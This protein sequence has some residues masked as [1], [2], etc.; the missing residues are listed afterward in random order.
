[1][2]KFSTPAL[3]ITLNPSDVNNPLVAI[4]AGMDPDVWRSLDSHAQ[5]EFIA[6]HPAPAAQ[7]F[8]YMIKG[9]LDIVIRYGDKELGLFGHC[10]AYYGMVEAQ[11]RATIHCHM[12]IWLE[13]NLSPQELRDRISD[14]PAF[15]TDMF[16]WLE[17]II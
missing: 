14:D 16:N 6:T 8:D 1:M 17:S 9:F 2:K 15:K 11:G 7:F 4:M 3:F 10:K 12:L 13:G 5:A